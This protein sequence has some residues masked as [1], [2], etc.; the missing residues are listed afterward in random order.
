MYSKTLLTNLW[1]QNWYDFGSFW[2]NVTEFKLRTVYKLD[3]KN[4][5]VFERSIYL[6][7]YRDFQ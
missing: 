2:Q 3:F 4:V 1:S 7:K 5:F 6:K